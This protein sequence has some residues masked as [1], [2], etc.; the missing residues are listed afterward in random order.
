MTVDEEIIEILMDI[1]SLTTQFLDRHEHDSLEFDED[2]I[3]K[4]RKLIV[5]GYIYAKNLETLLE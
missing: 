4:Y 3:T 5:S 1:I 2:M